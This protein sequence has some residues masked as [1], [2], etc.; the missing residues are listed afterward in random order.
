M[1]AAPLVAHA[2]TP[3]VTH[4]LCIVVVPY[5][6]PP[7]DTSVWDVPRG[8]SW[9]VHTESAESTTANALLLHARVP[10][11]AY[12]TAGP[13][14]VGVSLVLIDDGSDDFHAA[15]QD[16]VEDE[17]TARATLSDDEL[18]FLDALVDLAQRDVSPPLADASTVEAEQ[19]ARRHV[20]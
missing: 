17:A 19:H 8:S 14:Q 7:A 4:A 9:A 2:P 16:L 15:L 5:E 1:S 20:R 11:F 3:D 18:R 6:E 12:V 13:T 10:W